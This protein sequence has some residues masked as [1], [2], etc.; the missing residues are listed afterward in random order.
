MARILSSEK[1]S[2]PLKIETTFK[3][4]RFDPDKKGSIIGIT[5]E[6]LTPVHLIR[7]TLEGM[8]QELYDMY[9]QICEGT[10]LHCDRLYASGNGL[11]KNPALMEIFQKK[12]QMPLLLAPFEEEAACGA[13]ISTILKG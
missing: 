6:N 13:A 7:G 1:E 11:R 5:E 10:N 12:F 3:G 8:A 2:S 9:H 4:T